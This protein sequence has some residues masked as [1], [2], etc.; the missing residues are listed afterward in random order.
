MIFFSLFSW[1]TSASSFFSASAA[2]ASASCCLL[3]VSATSAFLVG[4]TSE[5]ISSLTGCST[6]GFSSATTTF[7]TAGSLTS[8]FFGFSAGSASAGCTFSTG[9][10]T[11]GCFSTTTGFSCFST[12]FFSVGSFASDFLLP[13][14]VFLPK[15]LRSI[16]PNGLYCC[17]L[18][19]SRRLSARLS[20][21]GSVAGF[22]SLLFLGKS[23][24][25]W[26]RISLS[27]WNAE[28]RASYWASLILKLGSAFTSPNSLFFSKNSTAVWSPM[29]SSL[30]ALFNL[31]LILENLKIIKFKN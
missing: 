31:I 19:D 24:S 28:T 26:L 16:L 22:F 30:N 6:L 11:F 13:V 27:C 7:S 4:S 14:S 12:T 29:F 21:T 2:G 23:L 8:T 10:S 9:G 17:W 20:F 1:N 5:G 3:A 18:A 15:L 25:A